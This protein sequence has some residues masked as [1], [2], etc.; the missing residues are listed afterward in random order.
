MKNLKIMGLFLIIALCA[1]AFC[2]CEQGADGSGRKSHGIEDDQGEDEGNRG[3]EEGGGEDETP[4]TEDGEDETP[5]E[6]GPRA[7]HVGI[8][9]KHAETVGPEY[10][11]EVPS[12]ENFKQCYTPGK[13]SFTWVRV[14]SRAE[15]NEV[16]RLL[17]KRE[18]VEIAEKFDCLDAETKKRI[19]QDMWYDPPFPPGRNG[20][21][22]IH[23]PILIY[24]GTYNGS[25]V[26]L[27]SWPMTG[28]ISALFT[29]DGL[30]VPM[31][32]VWRD[33]LK[34]YPILDIA[35]ETYK[36]K[37]SAY[38]RGFLTREDLEKIVYI[39]DRLGEYG[40]WGERW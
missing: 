4:V 11:P 9:L 14:N 38:S 3:P 15:I 18:D 20:T 28:V 29:E 32:V 31:L 24:H 5:D 12:F 8:T 16:L 1:A 6:P 35:G 39:H 33:G 25:V 19:Q 30:R 21:P 17:N 7:Y 13:F 37:G 10:F 23:C 40:L 22:E 26:Y 36:E 27:P 34:N 2:A